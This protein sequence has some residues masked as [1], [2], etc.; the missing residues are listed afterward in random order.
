MDTH[1]QSP[2]RTAIDLIGGT[3][4]VARAFSITPGAVSIWL[5]RGEAPADRCIRLEELCKRKVTRYALRP[6]VFGNAPPRLRR[7]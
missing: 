3:S 7:A 1:D 4:A 2:L 6:D 5:Q